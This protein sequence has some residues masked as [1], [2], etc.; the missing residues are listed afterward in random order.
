L[1]PGLA[2]AETLLARGHRVQMIVSEKKV[3]QTALTTFK[4]C[5][6]GSG[7]AVRSVPAVGFN[8]SRQL[9]HFCCRLVRATR[10][11]SAVCEEFEPDAVLGMGGFTSAPALVAARWLRRNGTSALIHESNA[12]PGR[13]NRWVGRFVDHVAVGLADCAAFFDGRPV[14]VTGTPIRAGLRCGRVADAQDRLGLD[15][16]RLTI[17]V[18]GGSQGARAINDAIVCALPWLEDWKETAQ[19]VHLC[20]ELDEQVLQEAYTK[21]GFAAKVMSFCDQ[22]QLAY[23]AADLVIARSGAASLAEIA[24]FELPAILVPY[25]HATGNHQWHNAQVFVRTGAARIIDQSQLTTGL[26]AARGERLA[27]V[28]AALLRDGPERKRM[29]SAA[30]SL[31]VTDAAERVATLLEQQVAD[32]VP[33]RGQNSGAA[34]GDAA[35]NKS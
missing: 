2:V 16:Q 3:D 17:L 22:M 31:A 15:R 32:S 33:S 6:G 1:F 24:A 18:T 9:I 27:D 25:P 13:A 21:N 10:D 30:R 20:G 28:V 4:G 23:S 29:A 5:A 11:C 19:F 12:V 7:L 14:T 26:H 35:H 8:G 34:S